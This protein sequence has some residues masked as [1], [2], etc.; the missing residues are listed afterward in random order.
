MVSTRWHQ[1]AAAPLRAFADDG[2]TVLVSSHVLA[3][4]AQTVDDVIIIADGRLVTQ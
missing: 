3:E 1:L 4:V 2:G